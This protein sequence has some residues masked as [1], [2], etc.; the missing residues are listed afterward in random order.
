MS[1]ISRP[2][3][4]NQLSYNTGL[5]SSIFNQ[6]SINSNNSKSDILSQVMNSDKTINNNVKYEITDFNQQGQLEVDSEDK[7]MYMDSVLR[8][9]RL[10]MKKHKLRKR[11]REQRSLKK[12]LGKL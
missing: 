11:R 2:S 8:K 7:T 10:K 1:I 12:R 5:N 3:N 6:M 9:R 4:I